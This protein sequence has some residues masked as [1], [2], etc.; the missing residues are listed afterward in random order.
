[1]RTRL[2]LTLPAELVMKI[3]DLSSRKGL[4][5]SAIVEAAVSS[6][7]SPDGPDRMEAAFT[8]RLDRISRQGQRLERNIGIATETL[9]FF[10]R[11]WLTVT[12]PLPQDA[13]ASA[14]AKGNERFDHLI[15]AIGRKL[16]SGS[17]ILDEIP[18]DVSGNRKAPADK[19]A[20]EEA[21]S[22]PTQKNVTGK[23]DGDHITL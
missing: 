9:A 3:N 14:R 22:N 16:Q 11:F 17:S 4:S 18:V 23:D 20:S 21:A 13:Q 6:F 15:Q 8:R 2:N 1:M 12:P 5:R 10:I 19:T 7:L